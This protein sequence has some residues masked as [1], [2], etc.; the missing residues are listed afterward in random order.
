MFF[1]KIFKK[2]DRR[3]GKDRRKS[4][5]PEFTGSERRTHQDRR[6]DKDRRNDLERRSGMY[7]RLSDRQK[8][9][10]DNIINILEMEK[11]K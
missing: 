4:A 5:N 1:I 8:D 10:M 7:Y 9:T 11:M 2:E 6:S 3:S